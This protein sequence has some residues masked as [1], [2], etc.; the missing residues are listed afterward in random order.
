M[1]DCSYIVLLDHLCLFIVADVISFS[2]HDLVSCT[3]T[4]HSVVVIIKLNLEVDHNVI[5]NTI[6]VVTHYIS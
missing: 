4:Y 6:H 2:V 1:S 5:T 3:R